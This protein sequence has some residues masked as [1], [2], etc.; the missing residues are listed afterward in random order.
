MSVPANIIFIG[1][2]SS[3]KSNYLFRTWIAIERDKG[4][5]VKNGLPDDLEYLHD[6]ASAHPRTLFATH[7][8]QLTDMTRD[9]PRVVNYHLTAR[10]HE[11][12]IVFLRKLMPGS[13]DKSYGIQVARL[14]GVPAAVVERAGEILRGIEDQQA[15]DLAAT[16]GGE[17]RDRGLGAANPPSPVAG[18]TQTLLFSPAEGGTDAAR[19][20]LERLRGADPARMT[21]LQALQ[22]LEELRAMA[23]IEENEPAPAKSQPMGSSTASP[24]AKRKSGRR[25]S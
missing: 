2:P 18:F 5:L 15:L 7:Y 25:R 1:G 6:G 4:R 21:P 12:G 10:E 16:A 3:G 14:A 20:V 8:H 23:G 13:T 19:R 11:G 9:H 17:R 24:A 22:V